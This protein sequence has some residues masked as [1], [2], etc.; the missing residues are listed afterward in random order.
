[1]PI[2]TILERYGI[3]LHREQNGKQSIIDL[4]ELRAQLEQQ[5]GEEEQVQVIFRYLRFHFAYKVLR[6]GSLCLS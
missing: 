3:V 1:M 4:N 5:G 2:E 6:T